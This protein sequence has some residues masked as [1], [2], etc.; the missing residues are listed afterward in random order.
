MKPFGLKN[1]PATF[2]RLMECV[3]AG[4]NGEQCLIYIDDIIV[5][6]RTFSEHLDRLHKVFSKLE[7]AG[8]KLRTSKCHFA[9]KV[10]RYLGHEVSADGIHPDPAKTEAVSNYQVPRNAK[11]LKQFMGLSNYYR[12]FVKDYSKIAELLFKLLTKELRCQK[13]LMEL[14]L[15]ECI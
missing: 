3:L 9:Q 12:R 10:V 5:F 4:L 14:F 1:A 8:L 6:S 13:F 2:Q 11:E 15:P 7:E